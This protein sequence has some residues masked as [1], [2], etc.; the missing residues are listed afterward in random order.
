HKDELIFRYQGQSY[1]VGEKAKIERLTIGDEEFKGAFDGK[2][3]SFYKILV[4]GD[5]MLLERSECRVKK[6]QPSKGYIA[7]TPDKYQTT[8]SIYFIKPDNNAV[9]INPK[10]GM[11]LLSYIPD[12]REEVE[13]Y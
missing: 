11:A 10:K 3:Y 12:K 4:T 8:Q 2:D 1:I 13:A 7:A 5:L 6:G 9:E